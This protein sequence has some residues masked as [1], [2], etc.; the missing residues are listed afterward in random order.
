M[1][2]TVCALLISV[3]LTSC[4]TT[5]MDVGKGAPKKN[6]TTVHKKRWYLLWGISPLNTVDAKKMAGGAT[7]Y[8]VKTQVKV[9]DI[10][11][12]LPTLYFLRSQTVTVRKPISLRK[13]VKKQTSNQGT[14]S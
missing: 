3:L 2:L 14:G 12:G 6:Y 8:S 10:L 5:K 1:R 4:F 9:T 13:K 11:Y 7:D